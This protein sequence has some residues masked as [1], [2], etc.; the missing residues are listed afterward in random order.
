[1]PR[2]R[3][4]WSHALA[5]GFVLLL[6]ISMARPLAA[7]PCFR[8]ELYSPGTAPLI[9]E[10]SRFIRAFRPVIVGNLSLVADWAGLK[11]FDLSDPALPEL[12]GDLNTPGIC[13]DVV[14]VGDVAY[15]ADDFAG[16]A[17]VDFSDP[18]NPFLLASQP[19]PG[20]T[21]GLD[22]AGDVAYCASQYGGGLFVVD[23]ADPASP[24]LIGELRGVQL[25][26]IVV[27]GTI[28]HA[29]GGPS[30]LMTFDVSDPTLPEQ[31]GSV[32]FDIPPFAL[33]VQDG[34]VCLA[35]GH[36]YFISE[37]GMALVDVSNP[38][39]PNP[40]AL[41]ELDQ[42]AYGVALNGTQAYVASGSLLV[43]DITNPMSPSPL[44]D[45]GS[46]VYGVALE[47]DRAI[48]ASYMGLFH[49]DFSVPAEP[50]LLGGFD[51]TFNVRSLGADGDLVLVGDGDLQ[52]YSLIN[53]LDPWLVTSLELNPLDIEVHLRKAYLA[54][55][56]FT[57]LDLGDPTAPVITHEEDT[58]MNLGIALDATGERICLG[59]P[60][61]VSVWDLDDP[62]HPE[63][64]AT[65]SVPSTVRSVAWSGDLVL[66]GRAEFVDIHD[67]SDM[68]NPVSVG[69]IP[70]S[71]D[72]LGLATDGDLLAVASGYMGMG[73]H[74]TLSLFSLADPSNPVEL[75]SV[76]MPELADNYS[77]LARDVVLRGSHAYVAADLGGIVVVDIA[78]PSTPTVVGRMATASYARALGEGSDFM[79]AADVYGGLAVSAFQCEPPVAVPETPT[80][81]GDAVLA[82][83]YPN[84]FNPSVTLPLSLE[85]EQE[86]RLAVYDT[87]GKLVRTVYHGHLAAGDHQW[88]WHGADDQGRAMPSG[89]Y[90]LRL[91]AGRYV[92]QRRMVLLR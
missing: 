4:I 19:L 47:N 73:Y 52:I 66:S 78:D 45:V 87:S 30:S 6:L 2:S 27:E 12:I 71:Y 63:H 39:D 72:A 17:I 64:R 68:E 84:P 51:S 76:T 46:S 7:I 28:A 26:D 14:V 56:T 40:L 9:H 83:P 5:A 82:P 80:P 1:M 44:T 50:V 8:S 31:L 33:D 49:Y 15:L 21:R 20:L 42:A 89:I 36:T 70:I 32:R 22:V 38:A 18:T 69:S 29:V 65:W 74:G 11:I 92:S 61:E 35:L 77:P 48:M 16:L 88:S 85:R 53:P 41:L 24:Q 91:E 59:G 37:G 43:F 34:L 25:G 75:G 13:W 90:H 67:C 57:V 79:V 58:T 23:V 60:Q 86:V 54:G 81:A 55:S 10:E 3:P 62:L